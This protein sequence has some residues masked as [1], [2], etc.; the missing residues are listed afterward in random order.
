MTLC[1]TCQC[2]PISNILKLL[3][4]DRSVD[5]QFHWYRLPLSVTTDEDTQPFVPWHSAMSELEASSGSCPLC[6]TIFTHMKDSY[7][8]HKNFPK[9]DERPLWLK[10]NVGLPIWGVYIGEEKP[11][12]RVSGIYGYTTTPGTK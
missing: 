2:L 5:D 7:H 10:V 8:Y 3:K 12:V 11:E 9:H 4:S 6:S 1:Q